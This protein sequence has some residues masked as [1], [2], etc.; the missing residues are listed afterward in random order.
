MPRSS[1]QFRLSGVRKLAASFFGLSFLL[2][3]VPLNSQALDRPQSTQKAINP[4]QYS[5]S[6]GLRI[7]LVEDHSLPVVSTMVW[8][9][10]GARN[11]TPGLTGLSHILEHML[12]QTVGHFRKGE[13]GATVVRAGGQFNGF[14]SDD[15]T[16]FYETLP[17]SK[18]DLALKIE[19]ERMHSATFSQAD[20]TEEIGRVK[21]ELDE[22]SRDQSKNLEREVRALSFIQHPYRN[23]TVGWRQ[24]LDLIT[25]KEVKE[26]YERYFKP[27]NATL[28]I[29][30][31]FKTQ[32][33]LVAL[34]KTFGAIPK[35]PGATPQVKIS[36]APQ[37]AERRLI[38][39]TQSK[40]DEVQ[41]AYHAPAFADPDAA[42]MYVLEKLLNAPNA[43]RIKTRLL[44]S[45]VCGYGR[46]AYEIKKDPG[47]F[48]VQLT[49]P[50][51]TG[52]QKMLDSWDN[53]TSQ[54]RSQPVADVELQRARSQAEFAVISERDG[55]YKTAFQLGYCDTMQ[56]WQKG[57]TSIERIREVNAADLLRVAKKFLGPEN[58]VVGF[59]YNPAAKP[60]AP[61]N[62]T[63]PQ[64]PPPQL[65]QP[66]NA[67]NPSMR[68]AV[69]T[70]YC[71]GKLW[72]YKK[73]DTSYVWPAKLA[74]RRN[75]LIAQATQTSKSVPG[76][77]AKAVEPGSGGSSDS[78]ESKPVANSEKATSEKVISEKAISSAP[79]V[80]KKVLKNG[81]TVL[82][83]ESHLTPIVQ[84]SG[85]IRAGDVF[86]AAGKKGTSALLVQMLN[87]G[88]AKSS[89]HEIQQQQ[90]DM[91]LTPPAMLKFDPGIENITFQARVLSKDFY[92]EAT[93]LA[94]CLKG[95][96]YEDSDCE[97]AK[98]D[99][100]STAKSTEDSTNTRV[101]RALL[102][103]V[104][105]PG[106]AYYPIDPKEK[107][108][109]ASN[110]KAADLKDFAS[111]HLTPDSTVIVV[112]G[113]IAPDL[114]FSQVERALDGWSNGSSKHGALPQAVE[115]NKKMLK[116]SL[117]ESDS[118]GKTLLTL[119]RLMKSQSE[120]KDFADLLIADCALT[121]HPIFSR[122]AQRISTDPSLQNNL[123]F[124]D[125]ESRYVPLSNMV[126]WSLTVPVEP[127]LVQKTS[128]ALQTE[129]KKF[130]KSG[131][132][133]D[134]LAEVKRFLT[135]ALP[136][137]MM[138]SSS[139]AAKHVLT[140]YLQDSEA[141]IP[142]QLISRIRAADLNTVNSFIKNEFKPDLSVL[143]VAGPGSTTVAP[144]AKMPAVEAV[145]AEA[146]MESDTATDTNK[147][148]T[149]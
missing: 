143:I 139:E 10:V 67:S 98:S 34:G 103:S 15:F 68:P 95:M 121:N 88:P 5:L 58:R 136:L 57:W 1:T 8:Y 76:Q 126:T 65:K 117:P 79:I 93:L 39:K 100:F 37:G 38:L 30:G 46:S 66:P 119:G 32:P 149:N 110:L 20:L 83:V 71:A 96:S 64:K 19:S 82:V 7:I 87:D 118:N 133:A 112:A 144:A 131:I 130:S 132:T 29:V 84:I 16:A 47:L 25:V 48:T 115:N 17:P 146:E 44:D 107:V 42:A 113:D 109:A 45:K 22:T 4:Q 63:S 33:T 2:T 108:H 74:D 78:A 97:K 101:N 123:V 81:V 12:F 99:F 59:L 127:R 80:Q 129:L 134:E 92:R 141:N 61:I 54:L 62:N 102:R 70:T 105:S 56:S 60:Y 21:N 31:D 90:E 106:S 147:S 18:L 53:L 85:A 128:L 27:N 111:Q 142:W 55:A 114:A 125:M 43:G 11:E 35:I 77:S 50:A 69:T 94:T 28:V 135:S 52:T 91:G 41:I 145:E 122:L 36:E 23:P 3:C 120:K 75:V 137:R 148:D 24:D 73:D 138:P 86:E 104:M 116:V 40:I 89:K 14:T 124:E 6:N 13:M 9:K 26:F 49:A 51:G 140:E 72:S